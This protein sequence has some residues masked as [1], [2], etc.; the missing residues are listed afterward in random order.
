MATTKWE[1]DPTHS[2]VNFKI[3]H[4]MITN[5]TGSITDFS[6]EAETESDDFAHVKVNFKGQLASLT[7]QNEQRDLHLKGEDF[8]DIANYPEISFESTQTGPKSADGNFVLIGNLT[9]KNTTELVQ[10]NVEF[11]GIAK[12]PWGNTKA[13]FTVD[14]KINREDFG[15]TWN[16]ALETGGVLVSNEVKINCELQLVKQ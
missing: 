1:L 5:V 9:I 12:D 8:F 10:L 11:G 14:T 3:K 7:T 2:E 4:L 6:V 13:G 16:A 15:L